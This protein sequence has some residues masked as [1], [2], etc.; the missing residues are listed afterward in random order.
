MIDVKEL[1]IGNFIMNEFSGEII[2]V[3]ARF[4]SSFAGGRDSQ[5]IKKDNIIQNY[6]PI[7]LTESWLLKFPK[8][9]E[10]RFILSEG[11]CY[12]RPIGN[13]SYY[14]EVLGERIKLICFVHELQNLYFLLDNV[15]L[16]LKDNS[17][18][19][20]AKAAGKLHKENTDDRNI[21]ELIAFGEL[22]PLKCPCCGNEL[23]NNV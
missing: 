7:P 12:L 15:N 23:N 10:R 19:M 9:A 1:R 18:I 8:D 20:A 5:S 13:D 4:F 11:F 6:N 16:P 14:F 2:S 22:L 21:Q 17:L 3:D